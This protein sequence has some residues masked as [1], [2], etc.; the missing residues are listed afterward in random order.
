MK[1]NAE[2]KIVRWPSDQETAAAFE[3]Y[4]LAIGKVAHAWN[5][6]HEKLGQLFV[7]LA[8]GERAVSL[9]IWY[10]TQNDRAQRNMLRAAV[11]G[12]NPSHWEELPKATADLEWLLDRADEVAEHRNNAVHAPCSLY[13]GGRKD[14]GSEMGAAF[15][16]GNPR[17]KKLRGK[18]LLEE[19]EWCERYAETL[20]RFT[21]QLETAIAFS[22]TYP[23]PKRPSK[24]SRKT[25]DTPRQGDAKQP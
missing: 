6:L 15:F 17:A 7:V 10:S 12:W 3:A 19:F 24:P 4:A 1:Q 21:G 2:P 20:S 14:G 5:Y 23:W 16:S 8:G 11:N 9:A 25:N 18:R 13:V 22:G